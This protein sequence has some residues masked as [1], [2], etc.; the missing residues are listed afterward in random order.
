MKKKIL[1]ALL[2][3]IIIFAL[4]ATYVISNPVSPLKTVS[5]NE[6]GKNITITYSAP[7]KKD[8]LIFGPESESAL[9]PFNKYWRTGA[10]RHTMI[11]TLSDLKFGN[12]VLSAGEYS[13]YTV[14]GEQ[15]WDITFN[16]TNEYFGIMQPDPE[17]DLFTM[18]VPSNSLSDSTEQFVI[19]FKSSSSDGLSSSAIILR[20]DQ[21]EVVIPFK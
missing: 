19:E 9:V 2:G 15:S 21:T 5:F 10:N 3:I 17:M 8:R 7:F 4:Y 20:W 13:M 18:S 1:Y 6:D 14:P 16:S 11:N 12:N